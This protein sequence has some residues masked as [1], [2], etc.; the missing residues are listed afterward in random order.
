MAWMPTQ[1]AHHH[2]PA[3]ARCG[4]S[5]SSS[6]EI[7]SM[8]MDGVL[9][10]VINLNRTPVGGESS[11]EH[12]KA[13]PSSDVANL[14]AGVNLFDEMPTQIMTADLSASNPERRA[15]FEKKQ[16]MIRSCGA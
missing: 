11:S 4:T 9:P 12:N 1:E 3:A 6:P 15:W 13:P 16:D 10:P 14:L 5:A 2:I 7:T 8:P